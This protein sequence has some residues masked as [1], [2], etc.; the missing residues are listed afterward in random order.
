MNSKLPLDVLGKV[1]NY[2]I[3]FEYVVSKFN[4]MKNIYFIKN[5]CNVMIN[6]GLGPQ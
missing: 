2:T 1:Q 4:V 5:T 3:S 6:Q